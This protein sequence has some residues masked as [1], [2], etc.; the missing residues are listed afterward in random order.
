MLGCRG[1]ARCSTALGRAAYDRPAQSDAAQ[2]KT[3]QR[4]VA[5]HSSSRETWQH[6]AAQKQ[7][8]MAQHSTLKCRTG[9]A[10]AQRSSNQ[11]GLRA[12]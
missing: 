10:Q 6:H 8:R 2:C 5:Q 4:R 1:R 11:V 7:H 3:V 9:A 12:A